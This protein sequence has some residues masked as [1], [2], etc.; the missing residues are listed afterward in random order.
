MAKPMRS[1]PPWLTRLLVGGIVFLVA[2]F[3]TACSG[4]DPKP[5]N[6]RAAV[7]EVVPVAVT[8]AKLVD[9][10]VYLVGLGSVSTLNA[11][12]IKRRVDGQLV[13]VAFKDGQQVRNGHVLDL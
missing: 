5:G 9:M 6:V 8:P 7:N 13:E 12:S 4:S 11:V 10:P 2:V 1:A 3:W